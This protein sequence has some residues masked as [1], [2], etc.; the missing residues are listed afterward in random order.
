M[1]DFS[2]LLKKPAGQAKKPKELPIGHYQGIVK[3]HSLEQAPPGKD[4]S[5]IVRIQIG[6]TGWPDSVAESDKVQDMGGGETRPIDLSKRQ[7][8]K[9][10]YDNSLYRLDDFIRSCGIE[11]N[12]RSYEEVLPELT[13]AQVVAEVGQYLNQTTSEIGNQIVTVVGAK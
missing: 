5:A 6:L 11:P 8:R 1:P 3:G 9:D 4:Y 7:L 2:S 10:F 12:G 13:G